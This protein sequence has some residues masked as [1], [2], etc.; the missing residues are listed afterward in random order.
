MRKN[1]EEQV[2]TKILMKSNS[3]YQKLREERLLKELE[4]KSVALK[5]TEK[6]T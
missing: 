5:S 2:K 1:E 3:E 6:V 4:K